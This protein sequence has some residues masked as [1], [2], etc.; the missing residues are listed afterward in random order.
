MRTLT[1]HGTGF[2]LCARFQHFPSASDQ[3]R[4]QRN[5]VSSSQTPSCC[6]GSCRRR[7]LVT[8]RALAPCEHSN[9]ARTAA[10]TPES[11][12]TAQCQYLCGGCLRMCEEPHRA[13]ICNGKGALLSTRTVRALVRSEDARQAVS[14]L[15]SGSTHLART[16][17]VRA[18]ASTATVR[19]LRT[20]KHLYKA[21][22]HFDSARVSRALAPLWCERLTVHALQK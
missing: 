8:E 15:R 16:G 7:A 22:E 1:L 20:C 14:L 4:A 21:S 12:N 2:P 10:R 13:D 9:C 3:K 19:A 18:H 5:S 6:E 17:K 11:A